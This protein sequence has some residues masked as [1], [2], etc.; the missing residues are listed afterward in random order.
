MTTNA[1]LS[2]DPHDTKWKLD[3]SISKIFTRTKKITVD[4]ETID[5]T[6]HIFW[7]LSSEKEV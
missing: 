4:K 3:R 7:G 1:L 6:I 5:E 2:K